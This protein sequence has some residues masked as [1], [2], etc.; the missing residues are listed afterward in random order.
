MG[1]QNFKENIK[2]IKSIVWSQFFSRSR[3]FV[4]IRHP[5]AILVVFLAMADHV[6]HRID[7]SV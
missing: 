3:E 5:D 1:T 4:P 6:L 2:E 7:R